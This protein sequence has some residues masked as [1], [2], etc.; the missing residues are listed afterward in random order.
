MKK[1]ITSIFFI[2]LSCHAIAQIEDVCLPAGISTNP[3]APVNPDYLPDPAFENHF[4][5]FGSENGS[6]YIYDLF[7]MSQYGNIE[8][9]QHPYSLQNQSYQHLTL[10]VDLED[11]DMYPED[12]W[13]L[14]SVNLGKYPNGMLYSEH[15]PSSISCNSRIPYLLLYNKYRG[16]I[17]L[18]SN[19]FT[20]ETYKTAKITLSFPDPEEDEPITSGLLRLYSGVD[21]PLSQ[22]T[23]VT[24]VTSIVKFPNV[25]THWFY[26]DFQVAFDPCTCHY[27]TYW[28]FRANC[29]TN[30]AVK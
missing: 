26:C 30:S 7:E 19:Y 8:A 20:E 10:D 28:K 15:D 22:P 11:L 1:H 24:T 27:P 6:L 25:D 5:W 4:E 13:E 12:G 21:V 18:F 2:A 16:I 14:L 3:A 9:M 17:R 29:T 23:D